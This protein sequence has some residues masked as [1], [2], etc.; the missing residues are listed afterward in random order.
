MPDPGHT[1]EGDHRWMRHCPVI[2][3][4]LCSRQVSVVVWGRRVSVIS[5]FKHSALNLCVVRILLPV[6]VNISRSVPET[7]LKY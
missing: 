3:R 7:Q 5:V 6:Y 2:R 4:C 1:P